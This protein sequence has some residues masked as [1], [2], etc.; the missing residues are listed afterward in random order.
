MLR[1][2]ISKKA[3][4]YESPSLAYIDSQSVKTTRLGGENS[5]FDGGKMIKRCKHHI[6]TDTMGLLLAVVVHAENVQDSKGASD[7]IALLKGRSRSLPMAV[8]VVN[9]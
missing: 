2:K 1:D 6:I 4:K 5:G 7:V 3:G 8:I 9:S